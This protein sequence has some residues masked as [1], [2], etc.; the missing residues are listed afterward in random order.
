VTQLARNLMMTLQDRSG[1]NF[2][3]L[4]RDRDSKFTTAFDGVFAAQDVEVAKIPPHCPRATAFAERWV[5]TVRPESTDRMLTAGEHHLRTVLDRYTKRYNRGRPH[6]SLDLR[7]R[8]QRHS[9]A[10]RHDP[11]SQDPRR[12]HQRVPPPSLTTHHTPT[13]SPQ[14]SNRARILAPFT[15]ARVGARF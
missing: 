11:T 12:T 6:R 15:T 10:K 13:K 4:I 8:T 1:S 14:A 9:P 5:R 2:R 7:R 3:F